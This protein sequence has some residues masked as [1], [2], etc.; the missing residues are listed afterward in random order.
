MTTAQ[1]TFMEN[2]NSY[3]GTDSERIEQALA[4]AAPSGRRQTKLDK[5]PKAAAANPLAT[6]APAR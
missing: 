4:A 5:S 3:R 2:P 1:S 6:P